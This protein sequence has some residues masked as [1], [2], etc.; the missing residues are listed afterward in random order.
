[1][2]EPHR[3][4]VVSPPRDQL[5]RPLFLAAAGLL[6]LGL[7]FDRWGDG[8]SSNGTGLV[9]SIV[10]VG[11]TIVVLAGLILL[12]APIVDRRAARSGGW[13]VVQVAVPVLAVGVLG[14]AMVAAASVS[15]RN[16]QGTSTATAAAF[17]E[18]VAHTH[19]ATG[20]PVPV[21]AP[22]VTVQTDANGNVSPGEVLAAEIVGNST[23][24]G[25]AHE[26]GVAVPEQPLDT[27]TRQLL[28][29]QLTQARQAALA[30]P[31]VADAVKAGYQMVTPFVPLI[32]AHYI[33]FRYVDGNFD[34]AHPEMLLYDG[35]DPTSRIVGLSYFV[36]SPNGPPDG[37]AGPNDHWHQ[38]IGLCIK[39]RVV[40]GGE[41]TTPEEC[42]RRGGT[43]VGLHDMWM[44][45]AW[46]VPGWDSPEGVFSPE[47]AGLVR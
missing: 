11:G 41:S 25:G 17:D 37:F 35:T 27:A 1:M 13:R 16:D 15:T 23:A 9:H 42:A 39:D 31:T 43:K 28:G 3:G 2:G 47:H 5:W 30:F 14:P 20:A 4:D 38:H 7:G 29:Q 19:D 26:H 40:V 46:V 33:N 34:L 44:V 36:A 32:G 21:G 18:S 45:H 12:L 8:G 6:L 22:P 10:I 24:A